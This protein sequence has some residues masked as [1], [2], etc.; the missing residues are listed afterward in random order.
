MVRPV[1]AISP[2]AAAAPGV[3]L[4]RFGAQMAQFGDEIVDRE[5]TAAA[6][7]RD[8][9]ASDEIR[10]LLYDPEAGF[11]GKSGSTAVSS[12]GATIKRLDEI[13]A[14]AT[15]GLSPVAQRKLEAA[16]QR[17]YESALEGI[18]RH[19]MGERRTWLD[20]ASSARMEAA[21]QDALFDVPGTEA[22][23]LTIEQELR[24]QA[25]RKGWGDDEFDL[26]FRKEAS[27]LY[28]GQI[29]RAANV[30]PV[31]ALGYLQ[32]H[33]DEMMPED[34][35][36]LE[37]ALAPEA[38]RWVGR[39]KGEAAAL[40]A[41]PL[42]EHKTITQ[43]QM[44]PARPYAPDDPI[45]GVI[46]KSIETVLGPGAVMIVTSGQE[47]DKPQHGSNRH[48]TGGAA[49]VAIYRKDG[50]Q[51]LATDPEMAAIAKAAAKL[52]A[53]GIGFGAEYMG[54]SHI[55]IDLVNPGAGQSNTWA[56]GANAI[57][58]DLIA[59]MQANPTGLQDLLDIEDP[60]EREGALEEYDLRTKVAAAEVK[61]KSA[62]AQ[63]AAFAVIES[64]GDLDAELSFEDK[65][66]IGMDGMRELRAYQAADGK[67]ET[68]PEAYYMLN[69]MMVEDPA[70]FAQE[71]LLPYINKLSPTDWQEIVRKQADVPD[72]S[73]A[74]TLMETAARKIRAAGI[75]TSAKEGSDDARRAAVIQTRLLRWQDAYIAQH[76]RKPTGAEIDAEAGRQVLDV[77]IDPPGM[78]GLNAVSGS[79][80]DTSVWNIPAEKLGQ[81]SVT[82]GDIQVPQ[83]VVKEQVDAMK[84][85]GIPVTAET[86][87]ERLME[88]MP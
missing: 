87:V 3:A 37:T 58:G 13:K 86:L 9:Y 68:D 80:A 28:Y 73:A 72:G 49:D 52:G 15:K 40:N 57:S 17:R 38:K 44:G 45:L 71:N 78:L 19:T 69:R 82:I 20:G 63:R 4:Q 60:T 47:G 25:A 22:H 27:K 14:A 79:R 12:Y 83:A 55:H 74:S 8:A 29:V 10:K 43:F 18:D 33:R 64:G 66:T 53:R 42:Y 11:F 41:V 50:T 26:A 35:I 59:E 61:A 1:A 23:L 84:A 85:A 34:V 32:E 51:V 5:A 36:K 76:Q 2:E 67:V 6:K 48:G 31:A 81:S 65:M 56:S 30:D 21:R 16:L 39:K 70:R 46:G 54:G 75:D 88:I 62:A 7:E 24:G 77:T